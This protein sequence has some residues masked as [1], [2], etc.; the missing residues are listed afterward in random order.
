[1]H[2]HSRAMRWTPAL[3]SFRKSPIDALADSHFA[4]CSLAEPRFC[5][6]APHRLAAA[7]RYCNAL[8]TPHRYQNSDTG[9]QSFI[10]LRDIDVEFD[11]KM[12]LLA[13]DCIGCDIGFSL[14]LIYIAKTRAQCRHAPTARPRLLLP[15]F[16]LMCF[17]ATMPL[18]AR[19]FIVVSMC[20]TNFSH[21]RR[22]PSRRY[23]TRSPPGF[24]VDVV[25][26][27]INLSQP[28]ASRITRASS[29]QRAPFL[30]SIKSRFDNTG[31][32]YI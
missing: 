25:L 22:H 21:A 19:H 6:C 23:S 4:L 3:L 10:R 8:S 17:A 7:H 20:I 2:L 16:N 5:A 30:L 29:G 13:A 11:F 28:R 14:T 24:A 9:Q 12:R 27:F 1:M 32:I 26:P 18:V 31:R 15:H